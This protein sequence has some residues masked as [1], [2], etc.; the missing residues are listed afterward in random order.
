MMVLKFFRLSILLVQ[1]DIDIEK[2]R[3]GKTRLM[4]PRIDFGGIP[5]QRLSEQDAVAIVKK[6]LDH[7]I[8]YIDTANRYTNSEGRIGKAIADRS[9]ELIISTKA[10]TLDAD[11]ISEHPELSLKKLGMPA[12]SADYDL[13][14]YCTM[15]NIP[16]WRFTRSGS[17]YT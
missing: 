3:L 1:E 11:K 9:E 8:N 12:G 7:G 2:V 13:C 17:K 6:C 16:G 10:G 4:V 15:L 14:P 5:I